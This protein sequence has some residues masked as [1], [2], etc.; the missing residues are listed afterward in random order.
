MNSKW[1]NADFDVQILILIK[2]YCTECRKHREP[3]Q[4][5]QDTKTAGC[6]SECAEAVAEHGIGDC[7][8]FCCRLA[9]RVL[10]ARLMPM[11]TS[12]SARQHSLRGS[13][14]FS[15]IKHKRKKPNC[16]QIMFQSISVGFPEQCKLSE[17][18]IP[19]GRLSQG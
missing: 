13:C 4:I 3:S 19:S 12:L 14:S 8:T 17:D 9:V 10:P 2:V 7:K 18:A 1:M 11:Q 6:I 16:I 15:V 5:R